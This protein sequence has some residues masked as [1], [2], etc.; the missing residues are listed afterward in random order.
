[1]L[2]KFLHERRT[3]SAELESKLTEILGLKRNE[4]LYN[5]KYKQ[6]DAGCQL[7]DIGV[8]ADIHYLFYK[9]MDKTPSAEKS[10]Y[11]NFSGL[12]DYAN[13]KATD[14]YQAF[15]R[16]INSKTKSITVR[17][18]NGLRVLLRGFVRVYS[19]SRGKK[20]NSR[21]PYGKPHDPTREQFFY[22][23]MAVHYS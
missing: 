3:G 22:E 7:F 10:L 14:M 18:E 12:Y 19:V 2:E 20:L 6:R 13:K 5:F 17:T 4:E 9:P 23:M 11:K 16:E 21:T 1:M 8:M 15:S